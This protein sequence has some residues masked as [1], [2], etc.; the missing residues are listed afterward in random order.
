[1][2]TSEAFETSEVLSLFYNFLYIEK[3]HERFKK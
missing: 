3:L 1:M 2:E